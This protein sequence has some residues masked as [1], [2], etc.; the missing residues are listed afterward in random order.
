MKRPTAASAGNTRKALPPAHPTMCG[1]FFA[2]R[3]QI[4]RRV[5]KCFWEY[6]KNLRPLDVYK[7]QAENC[8]ASMKMLDT[9]DRIV[10][11]LYDTA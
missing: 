6:S 7:R 11:I 3:S 9:S 2:A 10:G 1:R 8:H 5:H 4:R